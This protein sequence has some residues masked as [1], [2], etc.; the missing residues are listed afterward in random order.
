MFM[1]PHLSEQAAGKLSEKYEF[2]PRFIWGYESPAG[3]GGRARYWT[4]GRTTPNLDAGEDPLRFEFEVLD[5]EAT[6]RFRTDRSELTVAGG[7]RWADIEI[8]DTDTAVGTNLPGI[9]LAADGRSVICRGCTWH[10]AGV[11]G[12][13]WSIMGGDWEGDDA[14][15]I[16]PT[17][18]D[19]IV[20]Q[21]I[22]GGF[23]VLRCCRSCEFYARAVFEVQNW[24]S[25]ALGDRRGVDSIGMVGPGIHAGVNF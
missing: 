9:T 4:Y 20:V 5:V 24:R 17:R 1:R 11:C 12:A 6:T 13:R 15:L 10:W 25:D 7:I 18:D 21:E 19:N 22:Y 16:E 23:E 8:A 14:A 2:S 3:P